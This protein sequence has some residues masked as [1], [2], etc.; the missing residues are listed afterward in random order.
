MGIKESLGWQKLIT[1]AQSQS[2]PKTC[3]IVKYYYDLRD[4]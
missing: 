4:C 2:T 3:K 1:M